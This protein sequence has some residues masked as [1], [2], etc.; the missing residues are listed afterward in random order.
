M[1][2]RDILYS[3]IATTAAACT[4]VE[5][6]GRSEKKNILMI[7][8]DDLNGWVNCMNPKINIHTPNI[9]A[10]ARKSTLFT[11]AYCAAPYCNASRMAVF[12][13]CWPSTT[14]IYRNEPYWENPNR[15]NNFIEYISRQQY[16]TISA[17]KVFH[18][19][20][21]YPKA[22]SKKSKSATWVN[23]EDRS[24]LWKQ[25]M[26]IPREPLLNQFPSNGLHFDSEGK[27]WTP[28]F[29]WGVLTKEQEAQHPDVLTAN[30]II[31]QLSVDQEEPFLTIAGLYKPHLPWYAPQRCFDHYPLEEIDEEHIFEDDLEDVPDIAK[32]WANSPADH[33]TLENR[34]LVK[35]AIQGYKASISFADEQIGRI[36]DAL[37]NSKFKD[38]TVVAVWSDN[39]F[40][41]GEKLHWRKFTLWDEATKVPLIIHNGEI[42]SAGQVIKTPVSLID[43]FP[44]LVE[45]A[46]NKPM[47]GTDGRSLVP[48][49]Q[50]DRTDQHSKAVMF[51]GKGNSSIRKDNWRY[52]LYSNGEEELYNRIN[53][54]KEHT[55][56]ANHPEYKNIK[57]QL[58][59]LLTEK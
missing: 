54:P 51:W 36:M 10:L 57:K 45:M 29:D 18:G 4:N 8:I 6:G 42:S 48:L 46:N 1:K 12:T 20:Y 19:K 2:R 39:G 30:Y 52:I 41:L 14:G 11:E 49:I 44:T 26:Q 27:P 5:R 40:H 23:Q 9:D 38:N 16:A 33:S 3:L 22:K 15:K 31:N 47:Q 53:D 55:N 17:G 7:C 21:N 56:L 43:V 58:K 25:Q 28:H 13:G 37:N 35:H 59:K 32:V 50:K 34:K 24:L